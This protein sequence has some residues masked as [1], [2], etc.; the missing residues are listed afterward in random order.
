M[1]IRQAASDKIL[2]LI[3]AKHS[4]WAFYQVS[5]YLRKFSDVLSAKGEVG[6][7]TGDYYVLLV[8]YG[9]W[10]KSSPERGGSVRLRVHVDKPAA[11][12]GGRR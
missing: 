6:L 4:P 2:I 11:D 9:L 3:A 5:R 8:E 10:G 1:A 7:L 12:A